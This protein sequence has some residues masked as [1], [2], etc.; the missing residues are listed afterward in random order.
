MIFCVG[1]Y[2]TCECMDLAL[3]KIEKLAA[4]LHSIDNQPANKHILFAEDRFEF[5]SYLSMTSMGGIF[6][7][8]HCLFLFLVLYIYFY[9][10]K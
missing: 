5:L 2:I 1:V 6:V 8:Q 10:K 3:Q 9:A 7:F 4:S